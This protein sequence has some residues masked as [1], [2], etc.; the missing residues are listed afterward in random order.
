M[1]ILLVTF[2]AWSHVTQA[3]PLVHR[4]V[5]RGHAVRWLVHGRFKSLVT[6]AGAT[7]VK[8]QA[9]SHEAIPSMSLDAWISMFGAEAMTQ[10]AD[11]IATLEDA[12]ADVLLVDPTMVGVAAVAPQFP[13]LLVGQFGCIPYLHMHADAAFAVQASLPQ[14]E[15]PIPA[16]V[17]ARVACIG[18]LL[19]APMPNLPKAPIL[20]TGRPIVLVTQGTLATDPSA[21]ILPTIEALAD[22]PV[23]VI[24]TCKRNAQ[25]ANAECVPWVPF[26]EV[27]PRVAC[28]VSGAGFATMQWC[29]AAGVPMVQAGQTEDKPAVGARVDWSGLGMNLCD[30]VVTPEVIRQAVGT[31]LSNPRYRE[32]AMRFA[33]QCAFQDSATAGAQVIEHAWWVHHQSK[34]RDAHAA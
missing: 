15:L 21:V 13:E 24:A 8:S 16:A 22:E 1:R 5:V 3:M 4:L 2:D 7:L 28:V 25:A 6:M 33:R 23:H 11:M 30:Q 19:P 18:P 29:A 9:P 34:E 27:L 32:Q 10:A 12:P 20:P 14:M 17:Q 31:V 26:H